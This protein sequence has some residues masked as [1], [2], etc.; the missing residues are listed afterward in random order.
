[1]TKILVSDTNLTNIADVIRAKNGS[2]DTYKVDEMAEA[3]RNIESGI[4][5]TGELT[6]TENGT[7]DVTNYA[8]ANVNVASS[9]GAEAVYG[10]I[11]GT[12]PMDD[13][14]VTYVNENFEIITTRANGDVGFQKNGEVL[15]NSILVT[16][17]ATYASFFSISGGIT[18]LYNSSTLC[19][20][21]VTGDFNLDYEL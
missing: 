7:F 6:I 4:T 18:K 2:T 15:K 1:M 17:G 14:N 20:W 5:P 11:W 9:G 13:I 10:E 21:K 16:S 3:I 12:D 19:V 8:S